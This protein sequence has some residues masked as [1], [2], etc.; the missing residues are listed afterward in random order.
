M[1]RLIWMCA[2]LSLA[3]A[4]AG[5]VEETHS[6]PV[7]AASVEVAPFAQIRRKLTT[8]GTLVNNPVVPM[9]LAPVVKSAIEEEM[10]A[11]RPDAACRA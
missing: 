10:G 2:A 1:K 5:I 6:K 11:F 9:V 8:L 3:A 4:Q 7:L